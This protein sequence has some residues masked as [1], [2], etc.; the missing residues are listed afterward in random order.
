MPSKP[1]LLRLR[2]W[3]LWRLLPYLKR[4]RFRLIVGCLMV[5]LTDLAGVAIPWVLRNA[6]NTLQGAS[7]STSL[8][9]RYAVLILGLSIL[10]GVFRFFMRRIVIG[11]SRYIEYD[12]GNDLFAS[13]ERMAAPFYRRFTTG[14]LMARLTNDLS[15]VRMVLG[16]GIM[17]SMETLFTA[18]LITVLLFRISPSLAVL[19]LLPAVVVSLLARRAGRLIHQRFEKIQEQFSWLTTLAQEVVSGIR[20]VKAYTQEPATARRFEEAN[21]EYVGRSMR[22]VKLW[23]AFQPMLALLL[24]VSLVVLMWFGGRQVMTGRIT[25]G[26]FVAFIVYLGMLTWPT[27]ALGWVINIVERGS[28]SMTR[29]LEILDAEPEVRDDESVLPGPIS[30][31]GH[32]E[33]RNLSFRYRDQLILDDI[34]FTVSVGETLAIVGRT[35]SGKST[36]M[37]LLCRLY[38]VPPST[39]F[40]DGHDINRIPLRALRQAIGYVPQDAFLFSDTIRGNIAFGRPDADLASVEQAAGAAYILP[41]ILDLPERF[42]TFVGERGI[43]LSGGQKQRVSLSRALLVQPRILLL[44]DA[45]SA[46]DTETEAKILASL[47]TY[48]ERCT[49]I[50]ISHRVS[51]L[52]LAD[53]ILVLENGRIVERGTHEQLLSREGY[54]AELYR[55]QLLREEL[56]VEP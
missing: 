21:Q 8:L 33:V 40:I 13:L 7:F 50:L 51:T 17:Y 30:I 18:T 22:L 25:L 42:E 52:T 4:Y 37:N 43:T 9:V 36:L 20:V 54:Y 11:A 27:I 31:Q 49:A 39:I 2:S 12:L 38:P 10:G 41:D 45:L 53:R 3:S 48:L 34:S 35:G 23:G 19:I 28:A 55:R 46:V 47:R 56:E 29:L 1:L 5:L 16:P 24:G 26:D 15:A 32:I 14:D 6:A 44:D